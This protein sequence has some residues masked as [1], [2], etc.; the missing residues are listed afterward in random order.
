MI[1]QEETHT[2]AFRQAVSKNAKITWGCPVNLH[3][4][5]HFTWPGVMRLMEAA[6]NE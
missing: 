2:V 3:D 5:K 1:Q 4:D 6:K